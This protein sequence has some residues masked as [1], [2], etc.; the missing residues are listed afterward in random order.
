MK[1]PKVTK[2]IVSSAA[3]DFCARNGWTEQQA[4]DLAEAY[5]DTLYPDGYKLARA[6]DD[7]YYWDM[8]AQTVDTLDGF[9]SV[10]CETHK[11]VCIAWARDNNIQPPLPIGAMTT[12]GLIAGLYEHDVACY[13][14]KE[15]DDANDTRFLIVR[16][17]DACAA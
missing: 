9:Y 10:V 4:E 14:I 6:L 16:F 13:R 3:V 7:D 2:E 15:R 17:E 5:F 12:K 11:Q 8:D 1:R